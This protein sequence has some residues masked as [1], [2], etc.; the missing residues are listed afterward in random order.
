MFT[1]SSFH[2]G[3]AN[4][5]MC[6]GSVRFLKDSTSLNTVWSIGSRNQG[7]VISSDSY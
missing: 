2:P 1:L 4:V 3:G 7:E 5:L 6:D